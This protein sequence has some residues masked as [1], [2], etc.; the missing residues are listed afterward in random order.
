MVSVACVEE[1]VPEVGCYNRH[2]VR[3]DA[4]YRWSTD[5]ECDDCRS[6][7]CGW[8]QTGH[9]QPMTVN[10]AVGELLR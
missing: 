2:D 7:L 8:R 6:G 4:R 5:R 1:R 3:C 10:D 9:Q